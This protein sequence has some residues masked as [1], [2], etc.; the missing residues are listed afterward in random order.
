[1]PVKAYRV[2]SIDLAMP[3]SFDLI[4]DKKLVEFLRDRLKLVVVMDDAGV[5]MVHIP[6]EL[7][8]EAIEKVGM[9]LEEKAYLQKDVDFAKEKNLEYIRYVVVG[10]V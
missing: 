6:T 1:M 4:Q 9:N 5:A 8:E 10:G 2:Q 3:A 7:I